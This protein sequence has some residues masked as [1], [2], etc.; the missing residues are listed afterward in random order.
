[1]H[2]SKISSEYKLYEVTIFFFSSGDM[3]VNIIP[4]RQI[5][6]MQV[7]LSASGKLCSLIQEGQEPLSVWT[8]RDKEDVSE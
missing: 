7:Y 6:Q 2:H 4:D 1:M 8:R 5:K 3:F